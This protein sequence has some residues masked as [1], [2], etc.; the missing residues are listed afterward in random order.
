MSITPYADVNAIVQ[1][2]LEN[3]QAV[4]GGQLKGMYLIGSLAVGDFD[5]QHSDIDLIVVTATDLAEDLIAGLQTIHKT[6]PANFAAGKSQIDPNFAWANRVEAVYIPQADLRQ[7][8][9]TGRYLQIERGDEQTPTLFVG[10]I[11]KGWVFQRYS[12]REKGIIVTGPHPHTLLDPI[13]P[14]EMRPA[15]A[16]IAEGWQ[17]QAHHDPTWLEWLRQ[18]DAQAFVVLTLCR[19]LYSL[20]VGA[21]VS[22]PAA[23]QWAQSEIPQ[24]AALIE[25]ALAGRYEQGKVAENWVAATLAFIRYMVSQ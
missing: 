4:L 5:P 10:P 21:V 15:V 2:F 8:A 1:E 25:Y 24:Y 6:I 20:R 14:A 13:D 3:I 18:R 23:A 16:A 11:E 9:P 7:A 19:M 22:K 17:A 12:L